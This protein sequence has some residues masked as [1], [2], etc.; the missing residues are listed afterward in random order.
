[1]ANT[2][3]Y[4]TSCQLQIKMFLILKPAVN[5]GN[6]YFTVTDDKLEGLL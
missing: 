4:H 1:M 5:T 2:S 3:A 6:F